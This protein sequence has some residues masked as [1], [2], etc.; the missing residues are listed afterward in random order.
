MQLFFAASQA[1]EA[2]AVSAQGDKLGGCGESRLLQ[3]SRELVCT[4]TLIGRG[5]GN[6][7]KDESVRSGCPSQACCC[8]RGVVRSARMRLRSH[9][10]C[11]TEL[12]GAGL[13]RRP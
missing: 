4:G 5:S 7:E 12:Y 10:G 8:C 11:C 3:L 6:V 1:A 2:E 13:A 9:G